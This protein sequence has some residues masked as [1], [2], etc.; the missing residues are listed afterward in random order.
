MPCDQVRTT[1]HEWG[2]STSRE[3][4]DLAVEATRLEA[5]L[6]EGGRVTIASLPG[7]AQADQETLRKA[8]TRAVMLTSASR[9]GWAV[10]TK[11]QTTAT[12][13]GFSRKW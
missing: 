4:F 5:A 8:Y 6:G 2:E 11:K 7:M 1:E 9:F 10:E 12:V 3:A 13:A